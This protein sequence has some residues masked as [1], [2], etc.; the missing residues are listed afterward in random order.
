MVTKHNTCIKKRKFKWYALMYEKE[1]C[2][3]HLL[4]EGSNDSTKKPWCINCSFHC[5]IK[6]IFGFGTYHQ[7]HVIKIYKFKYNNKLYMQ[8]RN[9][10]DAPYF[11]IRSTISIEYYVYISVQLNMKGNLL[12]ITDIVLAFLALRST[13]KI[14]LG[15][16]ILFM[17]LHH[18]T[19][20]I[21]CVNYSS[22]LSL[23]IFSFETYPIYFRFISSEVTWNMKTKM[24]NRWKRNNFWII[25]YYTLFIS[26]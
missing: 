14:F 7:Y 20:L 8:I 15:S 21:Y 19:S 25:F 23:S 12:H 2:I 18:G 1:D 13:R 24:M 26:Y 9:N 6:F 10:P 3:N 16:T 5:P 4:Q 22:S 17:V 11:I